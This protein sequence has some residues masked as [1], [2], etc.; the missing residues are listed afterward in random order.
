[1]PTL[2][3]FVACILAHAVSVFEFAFGVEEL[4]GDGLVEVCGV[5][6]EEFCVNR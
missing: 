4:C 6:V 3:T 1:V 5:R 2:I